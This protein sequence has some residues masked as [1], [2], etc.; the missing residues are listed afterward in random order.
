MGEL[1]LPGLA[2][3]IDTATLIDQLM[4]I[5]S[6]RLA[7]YQVQKLDYEEETTALSELRT[8][9]ANLNSTVTAI[10]NASTLEAYK[11]TTS[12][13]DVL[14]VAASEDAAEGS[15]S[16][17]IDQLATTE[18]WIQDTSTF[19]YE[20]DYVGGGTFIY[21]YNNIERQITAVANE[22][23]LEDLVGLINNDEG[24]PGVTASLLYQGGKYHLL[25]S[26]QR[27]GEDNQISFNSSSTEV[28]AS[29]TAGGSFT[30]D[31][32]NA[33]LSTKI[34]A[35]DQFTGTLGAGDNA[36]IRITGENH[37]GTD[38]SPDLDLPITAN[39]TMG[40]L[41]DSINQHFDGVATATLRN[42]EIRLT[43]QIS[44]LSGMEIGLS[45]DPGT[46][47]TSLTLPVMAVDE[48]GGATSESLASLLS[49][50]FIQTQGSQNSKIKV[51]GYP[52]GT[53]AELQ[54][55]TPDAAPT[56]GH[57]HLS[58]GG[59]TTDEIDHDADTNT[60]KAALEALST[61]ST[62]DIAVGGG[63]NG[64]A[65]GALTFTFLAA[66]GD[67][68]MI[69]IDDSAMT[70]PTT[71][72]SV[73]ETTKGND[74]WISNDS[75]V[76]TDVMSG[77]TLILQDVNKLDD[78]EEP[79]P[80]VI[81]LTRDISGV[82]SKVQSMV[83]SYNSLI[84]FLKEKTEY[85]VETKEL[86]L[87][88]R[89]TTIPFLKTQLN[90]PLVGTATGFTDDDLYTEAR[91][92]GITVQGDR[93]LNLDTTVLKDALNTGQGFR[94]AIELIGAVAAGDTSSGNTINFYSAS[95]KYT[96][97]GTFDVEVT[98]SNPGSGNVIE[99]AR[100]RQTGGTWHD[101]VVDG[102][103]I[104]GDSTFDDN[105]GGPLYPENGLQLSVDLSSVGVFTDTVR[106]KKGFAGE[107]EAMLDALLRSDGRLDV[108]EDINQDNI[109]RIEE[110]I[111][112]EEARLEK[113]QTR[114]I[115]KFARLERT[116]TT[117][118]QQMAAVNTVSQ[119]TFG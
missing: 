71:S 62:D 96:T 81:T 19:D 32:D 21:S 24:N 8:K 46:G 43:D 94:A 76:V 80:V 89:S 27:T 28:W 58:Y 55:L 72:L 90:E 101:A 104:T 78:A 111:A 17:L 66:A 57:Y 18:T 1:R 41:I 29:S 26:G 35:L 105:G 97:A 82:T 14:G 3:G 86:G 118:N 92:I 79:I 98:I 102:N 56:G 88:S 40:H 31:E 22:T 42:G 52:S 99:S 107:L 44:G 30:D 20:T 34:T 63:A 36:F 83:T 114:L 4:A 16:I 61:V 103:I 119:I 45:Y 73:V 13:S 67:V 48:E 47:S 38:I 108:S 37:F 87:L 51:D 59:Q 25:L 70:G 75:N 109:D 116:L 100:I 39:T 69:S 113:V 23:T 12:D 91:E 65:D 9:V 64:L 53:T 60:I 77:I 74:S 68:D 115:E 112:D 7:N 84:T 110:T 85:N 106:V 49:T 50:S 54:T 10:S 15:H 11:A 117:L 2:T 33:A 95:S 5:N 6:R 93:T